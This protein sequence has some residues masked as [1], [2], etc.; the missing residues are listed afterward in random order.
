MGEG[1]QSTGRCWRQL[2]SGLPAAV[3]R[4]PHI[5]DTQLYTTHNCGICSTV[6]ARNCPPSHG[7]CSTVTTPPSPYTPLTP[8][9]RAPSLPSP[10]KHPPSF[11][12]PSALK[13]EGAGGYLS[14]FVCLW[15]FGE[16]FQ[17][18][19]FE[20]EEE[21]RSLQSSCGGETDPVIQAATGQPRAA[22]QGQECGWT[23]RTVA[24][25]NWH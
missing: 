8:P 12:L 6:Q 13:G 19:G 17:Q 23:E 18:R 4:P 14:S 16:D 5:W 7:D 1:G 9:I 15:E 20:R 22:G 11:S 24:G 2:V 3:T 21:G 25:Q 10:P